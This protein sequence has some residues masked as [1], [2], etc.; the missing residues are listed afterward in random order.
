MGCEEIEDDLLN[1]RETMRKNSRG[2]YS[3]IATCLLVF[4]AVGHARESNA[5]PVDQAEQQA[6]QEKQEKE[7]ECDAQPIDSLRAELTTARAAMKGSPDRAIGRLEKLEA[8]LECLSEPAPGDV[9]AELFEIKALAY[10]N[11]RDRNGARESFLRAAAYDPAMDCGALVAQAGSNQARRDAR[12]LCS[13]AVSVAGEASVT[14]RI[15]PANR[16]QAIFVDGR[17]LAASGEYAEF[18]VVPNVHL[19]QVRTDKGLRS[20][21]IEIRVRFDLEEPYQTI[22]LEEQGLIEPAPEIVQTGS[23]QIEN[24]PE[25]YEIVLDGRPRHDLPLLRNIDA[26]SR[27]LTIRSPDGTVR[28]L[29][30]VIKPGET[31][32]YRVPPEEES[33]P[34]PFEGGFDAR[35]LAMWGSFGVAGASAIGSGLLFGLAAGRYG[36]ADDLHAAYQ[37]RVEGS[38]ADFEADFNAAVEAQQA[39]NR[40]Q[41]IGWILS[42]VALGAGGAGTYLYLTSE[43]ESE[44]YFSFNFKLI[45]RTVSQSGDGVVSIGLRGRF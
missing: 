9:L 27:Y 6:N 19:F 30:V 35:N 39:G 17:Q 11:K 24:L 43:D 12:V 7:A 28:G 15:E 42:G 23:L 8:A 34:L 13:A 21:W 37:S 44:P 45:P 41:N 4:L 18:A 29:T 38:A 14:I 33:K 22:D 2:G 5:D 32:V 40:F 26:G 20:K 3:R 31:T 25:G 16:A 36:A 1:V 10:L